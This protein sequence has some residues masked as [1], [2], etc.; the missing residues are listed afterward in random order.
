MMDPALL[1]KT[2]SILVVLS[3]RD[4][5][6]FLILFAVAANS[7]RSEQIKTGGQQLSATSESDIYSQNHRSLVAT[8]ATSLKSTISSSSSSVNTGPAI[9]SCSFQQQNIT[10]PSSSSGGT[11]SGGFSSLFRQT[12]DNLSSIFDSVGF[13]A[14]KIPVSFWREACLPLP[15]H[16]TI[17]SFSF[18]VPL[19]L[20]L[21]R[22][23]PPLPWTLVT[24]S[25]Q[26]S[27]SAPCKATLL[28][29]K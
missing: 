6:S 9:S 22:K 24:A 3:C 23:Q 29:T 17:P 16:T 20:T 7:I 10:G 11:S 12:K 26:F 18:L 5:S 14:S 21:P 2:D 19:L 4:C 8:A 28:I 27:P 1:I 13:L 15:R 25:S